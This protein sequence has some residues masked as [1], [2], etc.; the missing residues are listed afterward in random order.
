M[1]TFYT[2]GKV[3]HNEKF[4]A[5]ELKAFQSRLAGLI[6]IMIQILS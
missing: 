5:L 4:Q 1:M 3:W 6:W 2:A